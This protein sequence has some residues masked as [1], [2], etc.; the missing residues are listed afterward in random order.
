V[1]ASFGKY[2]VSMGA[3]V[4]EQ[5]NPALRAVTVATRTWSDAN[6]NYVPDC[7]LTNFNANGECGAISNRLF[8]QTVPGTT[9]SNDTLQGWG[10]RTYTWQTAVSLQQELRPGLSA[11]VGY[12]RNSYGNIWVS[13]NTAITAN[14]VTFFCVTAPTDPRLPGG[15]GNQV[16]G[17]YDVNPAKFGQVNTVI[18]R[19]SEIGADVTR[20]YN[21][22]DAGL[23]GRFG[24]GGFVSGGVSIGRTVLMIA[25]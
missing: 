22:L 23:N 2:V 11:T 12:F 13:R 18:Q 17:N 8:G 20:V 24:R 25:R 15:G 16:C 3:G 6:G 21:G 9:F 5:N 19:S 4:A 14:D 7:D 1:K 10:A